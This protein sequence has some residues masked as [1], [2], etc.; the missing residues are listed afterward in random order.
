MRLN[1]CSDKML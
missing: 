1:E